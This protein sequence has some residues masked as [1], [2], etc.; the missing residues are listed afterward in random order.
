M[1]SQHGRQLSLIEWSWE[2]QGGSSVISSLELHSHFCP[3]LLTG[4]E[5]SCPVHSPREGKGSSCFMGREECQRVCGLH[6]H[7]LG[8]LVISGPS[9]TP[10]VAMTGSIP[11][12]HDSLGF[13]DSHRLSYVPFPGV[14]SYLR[15]FRRASEQNSFRFILVFKFQYILHCAFSKW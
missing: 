14:D 13:A 3:A 8:A 5:S 12:S 15:T 4:R 10:L 11:D 2:N 6:W 9:L 1:S 7:F